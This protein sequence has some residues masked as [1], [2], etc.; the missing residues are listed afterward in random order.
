MFSFFASCCPIYAPPL[1]N[2]RLMV[3]ANFFVCSIFLSPWFKF[4]QFR[5]MIYITTKLQIIYLKSYN[6]KRYFISFY[7]FSVLKGQSI[8]IISLKT[9]P[10]FRTLKKSLITIK[11][12]DL[13]ALCDYVIII[14]FLQIKQW[15]DPFELFQWQKE[16]LNILLGLSFE[17]WF[18]E[19]P[20]LTE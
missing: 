9:F 20:F 2:W 15:I 11:I 7:Q 8:Y 5:F 4:F 17:R 6:I 10:K 1:P 13:C 3:I 16:R 19:Y 14:Y 12:I 18:I